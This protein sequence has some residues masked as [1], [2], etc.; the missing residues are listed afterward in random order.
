MPSTAPKPDAA[1]HVP[2]TVSKALANVKP[3][4]DVPENRPPPLENIPICEGTPC[5]GAGKMSG[6]LFEDQNWLLPPNY[7]DNDNKN[8]T[9]I[10]SPRTL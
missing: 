6:N 8:A 7:L 10:T 2:A 4:T 3:K 1:V 9:D 5:P